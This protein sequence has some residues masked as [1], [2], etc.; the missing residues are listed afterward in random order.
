MSVAVA[1]AL[2]IPPRLV[3]RAINLQRLCKYNG[4]ASTHNRD[5]IFCT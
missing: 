4:A 1:E 2:L 5:T 3:L